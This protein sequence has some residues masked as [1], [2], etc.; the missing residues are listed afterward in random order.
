MNKQSKVIRFFNN[1][2]PFRNNT[3][4][5]GLITNPFLGSVSPNGINFIKKWET[6]SATAY[7]DGRIRN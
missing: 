2:N 5:P 7:Q 4:L 1:I 3:L 6:F